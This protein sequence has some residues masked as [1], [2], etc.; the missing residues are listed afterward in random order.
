MNR[1]RNSKLQYSVCW[2]QENSL[3][4]KPLTHYWFSRMNKENKQ[5]LCKKEAEKI[6]GFFCQED[7]GDGLVD[8]KNFPTV[9]C[10]KCLKV[11]KEDLNRLLEGEQKK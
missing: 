1:N 4:K 9:T 5:F 7:G 10:R 6:K 8:F 2:D 11:Y 3:E